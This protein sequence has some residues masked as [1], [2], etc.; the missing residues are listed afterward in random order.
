MSSSKASWSRCPIGRSHERAVTWLNRTLVLQ[1]AETELVSPQNSIVLAE[2]RSM[3]QPDI[4]IR[5]RAELLERADEPPLLIIEVADSSLRF[6]RVTK[7]RLYASHGIADY[8]IVNVQD[9]TV[10]VH[11]DP[12]GDGWGSHTV[13]RAGEVLRPLMLPDVTVALGPLLDFTAAR[14]P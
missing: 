2:L 12:A 3:P 4:A 13:R 9:E 7:S 11:R 6:D 14:T 5:T 10:E 1:L 8:W